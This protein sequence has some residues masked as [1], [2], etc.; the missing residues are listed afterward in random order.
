MSCYE[1][2]CLLGIGS[3]H[4]AVCPKLDNY[5]SP[6]VTTFPTGAIRDS[7]E[8]KFD[9]AEYLSP[10]VIARFA[11]Y[12]QKNARKYGAGNWRKGIPE[13]SALQS[14]RR[15]SLLVDLGEYGVELEPETDHLCG[16]LFNVMVKLHE[17]EV[18][19]LRS[20][21]P[22]DKIYGY[23]L[24]SFDEDKCRKHSTDEWN[25][26]QIDRGLGYMK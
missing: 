24:G 14:K 5:P 7:Q 26:S 3:I 23:T 4:D 10:L 19:K 1:G 11:E 16:E 25:K 22:G 8:N 17:E 20:L 15:H 12:M 13:S 9:L 2:T 6:S 18:A 21:K